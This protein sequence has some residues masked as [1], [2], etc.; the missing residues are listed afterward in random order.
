M[1]LIPPGYLDC[2]VAIGV[3]S[4]DQKNWVSSGF[5]Y[6]PIHGKNR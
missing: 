1:A 6:G 2:V 3:G 5:I 4:E